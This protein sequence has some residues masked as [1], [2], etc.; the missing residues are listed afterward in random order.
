MA[1]MAADALAGA[2]LT[3]V[4]MQDLKLLPAWWMPANLGLA[5]LR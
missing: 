2:T 3:C 4:K 5:M 1:T